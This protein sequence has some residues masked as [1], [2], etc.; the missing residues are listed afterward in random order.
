MVKLDIPNALAFKIE[1]VLYIIL[2]GLVGLI[3]GLRRVLLMEKRIIQMD[4]RIA[5]LIE[6][7]K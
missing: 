5:K 6:K 1:I 3:Y 7:R 4:R 2:G